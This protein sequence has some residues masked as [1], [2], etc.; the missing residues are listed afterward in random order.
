MELDRARAFI[1]KHHRAVMATYHPDG[2]L[3]LTPVAVGLDASG[4]AI[5]STRETAYKTRN[6]RRD[7]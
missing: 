2:S 3:Q 5:I 6:L 4:R 1:E 7:P